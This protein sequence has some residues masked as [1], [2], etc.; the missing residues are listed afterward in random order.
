ME[1]RGSGL[2][3]WFVGS[4]FWKA[5]GAAVVGGCGDGDDGMSSFVALGFLVLHHLFLLL[6]LLLFLLL[7]ILLLDLL[8]L[9]PVLVFVF[10]LF[11]SL[12]LSVYC[13]SCLLLPFWLGKY[14][15]SWVVLDFFFFFFFSLFAIER[16]KS[17][18]LFGGIYIYIHICGTHTHK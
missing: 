9:P 18:A 16:R 14:F 5:P 10:R 13:E 1:R 2:V 8:F 11:V 7:L 15:S 12:C 17:L 4:K 3:D 6:L